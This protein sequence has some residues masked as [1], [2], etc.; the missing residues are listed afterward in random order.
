MRILSWNVRGLGG[1]A[2]RRS[3]DEVI[4]KN[5]VDMVVLQ[6]TKLEDVPSMWV[7]SLWYSDS[8][9]MAVSPS[10]GAS[11]GIL[12]IWE[13]NKFNLINVVVYPNFIM[14]QGR[15][16]QKD[17]VCCIVGI[18]APTNVAG[19]KLVWD[20]VLTRLNEFEGP[21]CVVDDFNAIL[22][23]TDR[24]GVSDRYAEMEAFGEFVHAAGLID[25]PLVG[26]RFTWFGYGN[27]CSRIYRYLISSCWLDAFISIQQ[28]AL[29]RGVSDHTTLLLKCDDN[30]WG[31]RPFR[32]FNC[33]MDG[34]ANIRQILEEWCRLTKVGVGNEN[35]VVKLRHLKQFLKGWNKDNFGD[36]NKLIADVQQQLDNADEAMVEGGASE[37][38]EAASR[39][40]MCAL[41]RAMRNKESMWRQKSRATWLRLG[42]R[43]T[44]YFHRTAKL[45]TTRNYIPG[46]VIEG[47]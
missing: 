29:K 34:R 5:K 32:F 2:K 44:T 3:V 24:I 33:W 10:M 41:W 28:A 30:D 15:W 46:L 21:C 19:Q 22:Y 38:I 39:R 12:I 14:L 6:E 27:R 8:F 17:M 47:V 11:G 18:Y 31:P 7:S 13:G 25:L 9:E 36:V 35:I 40:W 26:K 4:R 1:G 42:D 23:E 37:E 45:R 16:Q 43:N 20:S